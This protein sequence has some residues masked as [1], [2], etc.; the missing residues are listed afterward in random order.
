[1]PENPVLTILFA[2]IAGSAALY[3]RHGDE[4]AKALV[5][6]AL[7]RVCAI[8]AEHGGTVVKTIGD[9]VFASF[10]GAGPAVDAARALN[11]SFAETPPLLNGMPRP[12]ALSAGLHCG[13][14]IRDGTDIFGDTVN[15]ASRMVSLAKPGQILATEEVVSALPPQEEEIARLIDITRVKG[16]AEEI[17]VHE[18]VWEQAALTMVVDTSGVLEDLGMK[19]TVR[20]GDTAVTVDPARPLLT[21]GRD[22]ENHVVYPGIRASRRHARI[23]YRRG[24][25]VLVDGSTNGTW[26]AEQGRTPIFL[27]R[28]EAPLYERGRIGLGETPDAADG[29]AI[30][31]ELTF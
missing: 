9:E 31:Y 26:L 5:T 10:P 22:E 23:E 11:R 18:I 12:V 17:R 7:D 30:S 25:Y 15:V 13:P 16:K 4:S 3:D 14:V 20:C 2:D 27:K 6:G 19:M 24:K 21:L 8:V 28:D 29:G 1:M